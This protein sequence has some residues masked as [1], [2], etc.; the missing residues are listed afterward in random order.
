M[1]QSV[2]EIEVTKNEHMFYLGHNINGRILFPATGYMVIF[3]SY[4]ECN[5]N[6]QAFP[7][8]AAYFFKTL[9]WQTLANIHG[10]E[11]DEIPIIF[12]NVQFLSATIMPKEGKFTF[13]RITLIHFQHR[14]KKKVYEN[15]CKQ[16]LL[17]SQ[18]IFSTGLANLKS[19]NQDLQ[20]LKARSG[21]Q[22]M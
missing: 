12:E 9:V 22:K 7:L 6:I 21:F 3:F 10:K 16:A 11:C 13:Y 14:L 15:C 5:L 4:N 19:A 18:L 2:I 17:N 1:G 20:S 8:K